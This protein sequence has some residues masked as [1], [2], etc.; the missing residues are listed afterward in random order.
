MNQQIDPCYNLSMRKACRI[1]NQFYEGRL[2]AAGIKVGQFSILRSVFFTK[3]TTNKELQKIL[4]LE[5]TTLTRN[6][7]P[8]FR[9]GLLSLTLDP[10]DKR[11]KKISLT[12]EGHKRYHQALPLWQNA[13]KEFNQKI[14]ETICDN[15][16]GMTKAFVKELHG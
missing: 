7:K 8:L 6:L 14:G 5:Q 11:I 9:D 2:S 12:P 15:I 4:V 16:F 13:Q 3:E 10:E 1:I